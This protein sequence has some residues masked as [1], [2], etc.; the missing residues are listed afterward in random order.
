MPQ[1]EG[2]TTKNT[3]LCAG[4]D[5]ERESRGEKKEEDWQQL[6]AQVPIFK[7]RKRMNERI[8]KRMRADL[9]HNLKLR[10]ILLSIL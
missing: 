6:L 9:K 8:A 5:L 3:Q 2:R 4:G 10:I 1:L 7:K